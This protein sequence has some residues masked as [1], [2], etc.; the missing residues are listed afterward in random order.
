MMHTAK[1]LSVTPVQ[2][3]QEADDYGLR[4]D[5]LEPSPRYAPSSSVPIEAANTAAEAANQGTSLANLRLP[6]RH[7]RVGFKEFL[8]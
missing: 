1:T 4:S 8:D 5:M 7:A 6:R 2:R 3:G